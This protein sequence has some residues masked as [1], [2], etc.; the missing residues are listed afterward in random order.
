MMIGCV[1]SVVNGG[2]RL[3]TEALTARN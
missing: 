1:G 3:V 2:V